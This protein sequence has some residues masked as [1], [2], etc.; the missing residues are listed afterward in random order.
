ACSLRVWK[1]YCSAD[2]G[3]TS[4]STGLLIQTFGWRTTI[5]LSYWIKRDN[6]KV[7]CHVENNVSRDHN[8]IDLPECAGD[9]PF[10][11]TSS[12]SFCSFLVSSH[13]CMC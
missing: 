1:V 10:K 13:G 12:F 6:E 4:T 3:T 11:M 8:S 5:K 7:T 9:L 2:L